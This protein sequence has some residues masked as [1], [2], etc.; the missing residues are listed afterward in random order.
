MTATKPRIL[1]LNLK[2][3]W[4]NEIK[5]GAKTNELR[6]DT[7]YWGKRLANVE[8]D[9]IHLLLGYPPKT[10]TSKLIR[11]KWVSA[12]KTLVQ[13]EEFG[14]NAV[15]VFAIDVSQPVD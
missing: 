7:E 3:R 15:Y 4:W 12:E 14:P 9:E 13:H 2:A 11:R 1:R 6:L 10:D 5:S 8:Y